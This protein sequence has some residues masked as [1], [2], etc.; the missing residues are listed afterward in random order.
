VEEVPKFV[1]QHLEAIAS[2]ISRRQHRH[3]MDQLMDDNNRESNDLWYGSQGE[4]SRLARELETLSND[5]NVD[6][7]QV[8]AVKRRFAEYHHS[9]VTKNSQK[10]G[11]LFHDRAMRDLAFLESQADVEWTDFASGTLG[12]GVRMAT[13]FA[14][15][16][17]SLAT[18]ALNIVALATNVVP[19][20]STYNQKNNFGGGFG[21]RAASELLR[22]GFIA[23]PGEM[24]FAPYYKE[25]MDGYNFNDPTST[26]KAHVEAAKRIEA[27]GL[28]PYEAM[29]LYEQIS[30][31]VM[32]AALINAMLGS[33]RGRVTSGWAQKGAE[34]WMAMFSH[35]EQSA[36]RMTGLAAYRLANERALA[37]GKNFEEA[38][39]EASKF[40]ITAINDTLGEYGMFNRPSIFRGGVQQF[41]FMYKMFP[42]TSLLLFKNMNRNGRLLMLGTLMLLSGAKGLPL[43][44]DFMDILDTIAQRTGLGP[45]GV[46]KGSAERTLQEFFA[47]VLPKEAVPFAMRGLVNNFMPIN[48]SDRVSLGNVI[49]GTGLGLKGVETG[50][51]WMEVAGPIASFVVDTTKTGANLA[52]WAAGTLP[53]TAQTIDLGTITRDSPVT[54][55]RAFGDALAY[56][57]NGMVTNNRGQV[58]SEEMHMG[59][60]MGRLLGFYP[61]AAVREY[62]TIRTMTRV[63]GYQKAIVAEFRTQWIKARMAGDLDAANRVVQNVRNWNDSARDTE[64][65]IRNFVPNSYRALQ[66]AKLTAT[67]RYKKS[68]PVAQRQYV[69][70]IAELFGATD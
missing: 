69:D 67:E 68:S 37:E 42:L 23:K 9:F 10:T 55:I 22:A 49:P 1:S 3:L 8:D 56:H 47:G 28:T 43:G 45:R 48:M 44:D 14:Q 41:I 16:G 26:D 38:H 64:L 21:A 18:A 27:A 62:D 40:A 6:P 4:Y 46:W 54:M 35:S 13:T 19:F 70:N 7:R 25:L 60:I 36:R 12:S 52:Q 15:L 32:Q 53:G 31:G 51:E 17:G 61:A 65:E 5:P 58:V 63:N 57:Q 59:T 20:L 39:T 33:S 34:A 11:N 29:F 2:V 30:S 66:A 24:A 50:R